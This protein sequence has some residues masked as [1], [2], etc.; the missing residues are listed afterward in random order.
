MEGFLIVY[1]RLK[2]LKYWDYTGRSSW[3]TD[4]VVARF[5]DPSSRARMGHQT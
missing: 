2:E 3:N 1:S 5:L 4:A